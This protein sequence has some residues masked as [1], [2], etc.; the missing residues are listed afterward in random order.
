MPRPIN[1]GAS[2]RLCFYGALIQITALS[3]CC[4]DKIVPETFA[5]ETS[6]SAATVFHHHLMGTGMSKCCARTNQMGLLALTVM[7]ASNMMG[8]GVF[9]LPATLAR[10]GAISVWGWGV[11]FFSHYCTGTHLLQNE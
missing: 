8:S 10:I 9:M 5:G 7:T 4:N 11:A 6:D 2:F 3:I 1:I